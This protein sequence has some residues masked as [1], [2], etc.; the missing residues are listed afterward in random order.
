MADERP[1]IGS[2]LNQEGTQI[3]TSRSANTGGVPLVT[4]MKMSTG[5]E[6]GLVEDQV[7]AMNQEVVADLELDNLDD[8]M[9]FDELGVYDEEEKKESSDDD[10][11][12]FDE[13]EFAIVEQEASTSI[14][15][16]GRKVKFRLRF[17]AQV[18]KQENQ[19]QSHLLALADTVSRAQKTETKRKAFLSL[20]QVQIK[21][22]EI[23]T[24]SQD[25]LQFLSECMNE[26]NGP[27]QVLDPER[28]TR[29]LQVL[30]KRRQKSMAVDMGKQNSGSKASGK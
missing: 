30:K 13:E 3:D 16:F 9:F 29:L 19:L 7:M 27:L 11:D 28:V 8:P 23:Y 26:E 15:I 25:D 24:I 5:F 12:D 1:P 6:D 14:D 22:L 17:G 18:A 4:G 10:E 20:L 21:L 2:L